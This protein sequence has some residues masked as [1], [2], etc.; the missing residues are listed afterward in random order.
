MGARD[1]RREMR[2][3]HSSSSRRHLASNSATQDQVSPKC[4]SVGRA[5]RRHSHNRGCSWP[6]AGCGQCCPDGSCPCELE[7]WRRHMLK[8]QANDIRTK[9]VQSLSPFELVGKVSRSVRV[10][11]VVGADDL[12]A[13]PE[14]TK[15]YG[16]ALRREGVNVRLT[17]LPRLKHDILL[18]PAIFQHLKILLGGLRSSQTVHQ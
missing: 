7:E 4:H 18:E 16:N 8:L 6:L 9:P 1:R 15:K 11:L 13:P 3:L 14:L 5:L 10:D 2:Q 12:V 17:V